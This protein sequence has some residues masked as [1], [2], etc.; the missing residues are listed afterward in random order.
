MSQVAIQG[1]ASGSGVFTVASPNSNNSR[2]FNLPD[3]TGTAVLDSATQTLTNKTL[4]SPTITGGTAAGTQI[5]G[6]AVTQATAQASTSG[7]FIDFTGIP[8]WAKRV[9]VALSGVSTNGSSVVLAQLGAGSVTTS[10]YLGMGMTLNSGA[11]VA[12]AN[13]TQGFGFE[14]AGAASV[15]RHGQLVFVNV[16]SNNWTCTGMLARSDA[17]GGMN[18]AGS[19]TLGGALDR[20]RITTVGGTDTF[21]AGSINILYEG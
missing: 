11:V 4:T 9:T 5:Q 8:A 21:D 2:T 14:T 10:G 12:A 16:S 7:T 15:V 20:V 3:A 6:G 18:I 1:N 19:V 13:Y 17:A